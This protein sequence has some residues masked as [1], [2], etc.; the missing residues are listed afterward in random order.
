MGSSGG[1][2]KLPDLD[3]GNITGLGDDFD[4]TTGNALNFLTQNATAGLVGYD[5][6]KIK[7]GFLTRSIDEGL[8][9]ITGRNAARGAANDAKKALEEQK[10]LLAK[11]RQAEIERAY[12]FDLMASNAAGALNS[13]TSL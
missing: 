9:E 5:E 1:G 11:E 10:K 7:A 8:G 6:G 2:I 13:G 3:V 4:L 12:Q